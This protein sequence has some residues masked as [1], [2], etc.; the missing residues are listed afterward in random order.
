MHN[1]LDPR[2]ADFM[3]HTS[4]NLWNSAVSGDPE[5][6]E[7]VLVNLLDVLPS[8]VHAFHEG[9]DDGKLHAVK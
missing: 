3:V 8:Y 5:L 9:G 7:A 6:A 4:K 1:P 2:I